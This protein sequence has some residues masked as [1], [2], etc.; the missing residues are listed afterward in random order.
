MLYPTHMYYVYALQSDVGKIY[1]GYTSDLDRRIK[2]HNH[3][4]PNKK[5]SF[6]SKH[7]NCWRVV[8]AET[9]VDRAMALKRERELKSYQGRLF[10][11]KLLVCALGVPPPKD[12]PTPGA[13]NWSIRQLVD[14]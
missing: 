9:Y 11:K 8:H 12:G 6:T 7:G 2:R 14:S 1:V 3:E 13:G 5:S 4:L 10:I